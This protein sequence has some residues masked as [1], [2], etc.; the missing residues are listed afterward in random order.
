M[1]QVID[2][3][4]G[5]IGHQLA[6]DRE[7]VVGQGGN[8]AIER[9]AARVL[10]TRLP[11][12]E[13]SHAAHFAMAL[14]CIRHRADLVEPE[15]LREVI[16]RLNDAHGT[17]NTDSSGYHHIITIAS[18]TAA[19]AVH[20]SHNGG[21]PLHTVLAALLSG[22]NGK[23]DCILEYWTRDR[24]FSFEAQRGWGAPD[25]SPLPL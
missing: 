21:E 8:E 7:Y 9:L 13:W 6:G 14:W 10:D 19:R 23:S 17:A 16:L 5:R 1:H 22:P 15:G 24:L 3:R 12:A 2:R 20:D 4:D 11:H 18:L 25:R